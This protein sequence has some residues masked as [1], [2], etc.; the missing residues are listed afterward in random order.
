MKKKILR[1]LLA[2]I[3]TLPA[4]CL[5]SLVETNSVYAY[6]AMFYPSVD[7]RVTDAG[8]PGTWASLVA[9]NGN[10]APYEE[11]SGGFVKFCAYNATDW[12]YIYRGAFV[13]DISSLSGKTITSANFSVYG[14]DKYQDYSSWNMDMNVYQFTPSSNTS[15][16]AE[17]YDSFGT[18]VWSDNAITYSSFNDSGWNTFVLNSTGIAALQSAANGTGTFGIGAR[19]AN[20]DTA[21]SS[22]IHPGSGGFETAFVIYFSEQG[23]GYRPKLDIT[24]NSAPVMTDATIVSSDA[25]NAYE[26]STLTASGTATDA[27]PADPLSYEY[28]WWVN[29]STTGQTGTTL[30][31]T[32]FNKGDSVTCKIRASDGTD[33]SDWLESN[34][35]TIGNSAPVMTDATIVSS[36]A[37]NAYETSTLTASGTATDADP[38]DPLSYE[39]DWWVN[40]ST[41]GQTG[42]TLDGTYFNKGDSVT[43]KIRASDGTDYSDWLE[44]NS[45]TIGNSAPVMTDATIVSSDAP[46][47]YETSTLTASGTATDADPADPLSYEYDWWVNGSTTGQTGTTLDGTYFNKGD[48]V[49]CKIRASD[50]TDYSDWLESNE[51]TVLSN[52]ATLSNLAISNGTLTPG[53]APGTT[54]YNAKVDNTVGSISVTPTVNESHATVTINGH[55][56]VSGFAY[57]PISLN[58]GDNIITILVTAQNTTTTKT[59][60]L[61]VTRQSATGVGGGG[62]GE[63][64]HGYTNVGG[65]VTSDGLFTSNVTAISEDQ[66]CWVVVP[67]GTIGL[68]SN[69]LSL[70]KIIIQPMDIPPEPPAE[71]NLIGLTYYLGP[72]GATFDP[73]VTVYIRYNP[74]TI[75]AVVNE[76]N[77]VLAFFD[78]ATQHWVPLS[79]IVVDTSTH[80]IRGKISHFS[81]FGLIAY[82][83]P[84][85]FTSSSLTISPQEVKTDESVNIGVTIAN[86]GDL[87]GSYDVT[88]KINN[89]AVE[90]KRV[91]LAGHAN[92]Q[93]VFTINRN[94]AGSYS[95][96]IDML[97][98][99]FTVTAVPEPT[100]TP[101]PTSTPPAPAQPTPSIPEITPT[102]TPVPAEPTPSTPEVT[103]VEAQTHATISWQW[104]LAAICGA[105]IVGLLIYFVCWRTQLARSSPMNP[106]DWV[107]L[108]VQ[109]INKRVLKQHFT[110]RS[111]RRTR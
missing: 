31:G 108:K 102:I 28:D 13:F 47:A 111:K 19:N 93:L 11:S 50:G 81:T 78:E 97:S 92:Q 45:I 26:T 51:I 73:P 79:D 42:T 99:T 23:E 5:F 22:P 84:A 64:P 46:N 30:D 15:L 77:L 70:T 1:I 14:T 54:T 52:D 8:T 32:Y 24:F 43:C 9:A 37:P 87:A 39:Y 60:T 71:S 94:T 4:V 57:G 36:D 44:S 63:L 107:K 35:I 105:I 29:G 75:P 72:G 21:N 61:T 96:N 103:P 40:G 12:S 106:D 66:L 104:L 25:P 109:N 85:A 69:L 100:P 41:T 88:L 80:T 48:S 10:S 27:D 56:A 3:I 91:S 89:T 18:T 90:T 6:T 67:E 65:I 58:V 7:G 55:T 16:S 49:T 62:G 83:R 53:F 2:L 59:Y 95:V 17:D 86:S 34:S 76:E 101:T 74:A 68:R 98:G 110:S 33:Y 82:T 20:Y 38:A